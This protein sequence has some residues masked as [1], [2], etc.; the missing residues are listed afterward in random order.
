MEALHFSAGSVA[1]MIIEGALMMLI[2]IV[3][4]II[5]EIKTK[6]NVIP[7]IVGA[8]TWFLFAIILKIAPAY[9]LLQ[10]N[11][12][13]AKAISGNVWLA[14]LVAG[15]LA[16]VFEETGRFL[17]FKFVLRKFKDRRTSISYGI[18]HGGFESV[19]IGF[20]M[21]SL[22]V[23]C[24]L[25]SSPFASL[26]TAGMDEASASLLVTQ[27]Q[28]Y[29][30]LSF[31]MCMLG[32]FERLPAITL[33]ISLSVLV[34]AAAREKRFIYLYPAAILLHTLIDFSIAFTQSGIVPA[35]A[36]ELIFAFMCA[37]IAVPAVFIYKKLKTE[38]KKEEIVTQ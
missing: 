37:L 22:A 24:I 8:A 7:V 35:W 14:Y 15:I 1:S 21:I 30:E 31:G 25:V 5:W 19:Y 13:V 28:P 33:H 32:V 9:L 27:L 20:Q 6:Y 10:A 2:P 36:F 16:G 4:L 11:N 29:S 17:A 18:G 34:F 12:P 26:I 23:V 38:E 3:L